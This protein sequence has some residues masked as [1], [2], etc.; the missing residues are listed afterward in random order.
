MAATIAPNPYYVHNFQNIDVRI[1]NSGS[2]P[3][4]SATRNTMETL[5]CYT[6]HNRV[7]GDILESVCPSALCFPSMNIGFPD[8]I[9]HVYYQISSKPSILVHITLKKCCI[10]FGLWRSISWN[11]TKLAYMMYLTKLN[12]PIDF[13]RS[14][15]KVKVTRGQ[16]VKNFDQPY[17]GNY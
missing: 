13:E 16:K 12:M 4:F 1:T 7:V 15:S 6:P 3:T 8:K 2:N 9:C 10:H 17:L 11:F 5:S 14:R